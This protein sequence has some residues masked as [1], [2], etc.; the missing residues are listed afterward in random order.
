M[1]SFSQPQRYPYTGTDIELFLID[2][3][4]PVETS[5]WQVL[6]RSELQRSEAFLN[7]SDRVHYANAHAGLRKILSNITGQ[8]AHSLKFSEGA[9]GK[10]R[11]AGGRYLTFNMAHSNG[12]ALVAVCRNSGQDLP[13]EVGVDMEAVGAFKDQDSLIH[14]ICT[15]VEKR[16][17]LSLPT[18]CLT[19]A[20]FVLWTRKEACLKAL[21]V[22]LQLEPNSFHVG[23]SSIPIQ[24]TLHW[25]GEPQICR[26]EPVSLPVD[27]LVASVAVIEPRSDS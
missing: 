8:S 6:S 18:P 13:P 27:G 23:H 1:L 11:L 3:K 24:T 26:L 2:L 20:L 14:E 17:I 12:W 10:P 15:E 16:E 5:D 4:I 19:Q 22:G 9:F 25:Q 21:G 7:I